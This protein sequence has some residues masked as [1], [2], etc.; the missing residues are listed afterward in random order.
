MDL[1]EFNR[2]GLAKLKKRLE[3]RIPLTVDFDPGVEKLDISEE[4]KVRLQN[5]LDR[6]EQMSHEDEINALEKVEVPSKYILIDPSCFFDTEENNDAF[7]T[8]ISRWESGMAEKSILGPEYSESDYFNRLRVKWQQPRVKF[9]PSHIGAWSYHV[10]ETEPFMY[11]DLVHDV[12]QYFPESIESNGVLSCLIDS[13][14]VNERD[15]AA[16]FIC[17]D[18]KG[19]MLK[20]MVVNGNEAQIKVFVQAVGS[21]MIAAGIRILNEDD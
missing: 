10:R 21:A 13:K 4:A 14:K 20:P 1:N 12:K 11:R 19:K 7:C 6:I 17:L 18:D 9:N 16:G 2:V 8:N 3:N 15:Y 5:T